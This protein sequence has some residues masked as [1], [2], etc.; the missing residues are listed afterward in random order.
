M[1]GL[2][3]T[4]FLALSMTIAACGGKSGSKGAKE[5]N[6]KSSDKVSEAKA[7]LKDAKAAEK[8][9]DA[10][11]AGKKYKRALKLRPSHFETV[12]RYTQFLITQNEPQD[13]VRVASNYLSRTPGELKGYH[14]VSDAQMAASDWKGAEITLSDLLELD[15]GDALA[16][17]KR[18]KVHLENKNYEAAR[19]DLDKAIELDGENAEFHA[20]KGMLLE[21]EGEL[22]DAEKVLKKALA[23]DPGNGHALLSMGIVQRGQDEAEKALESHKKAVE[24][25]PGEAEAHF[26]L[27][28]SLFI[29]GENEAAEKSLLKAVE[30]DDAKKLYWYALGQLY[31]STERPAEAVEPYKKTLTIDPDYAKAADKLGQVLADD[32]QASADFFGERVQTYNEEARSWLYLGQALDKLK[33]YAEAYDALKKYLVFADKG[34]REYNTVKK[35]VKKL[36]RLR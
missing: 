26:Q 32:A 15:S 14:L 10:E 1:P 13:A 23:L 16:M 9:G 31:R 2:L 24:S 4:V 6:G 33:K 28:L 30:M 34:E 27:G 8:D 12:E 20:T 19:V 22:D 21:R 35:R 11:L 29:M 36:K 17:Q 7:A 25:I 5:P 18:G 3:F